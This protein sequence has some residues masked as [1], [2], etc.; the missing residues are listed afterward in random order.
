MRILDPDRTEVVNNADWLGPMHLAEMLGYTRQITVAQL[1]ERDDFARRFA[2]N[3]A[4][5]PVGVLLPAAAGHRLG[6]DPGRHRARRHR[7]DVQ[8]PGR[9]RAAARRADR[10]PRPCSTVPLLVGTDGVEKMG[11]SLGNYIAIDEPA[12]EQFG[13][14][15]SIPDSRGRPVRASC[16]PRCTPREVAEIEAEVEAGRRARRTRPNGGWPARSSRST[17]A[18]T[19]RRRPRQRFDAMFKRGE[20]PADAARHRAAGRGSGP[21]AR[22]CWSRPGSPRAPARPAGTSMPGRS[23]STASRSRPSVRPARDGSS[24]DAVLTVGKRRAVRL[25]VSDWPTKRPGVSERQNRVCLATRG[26]PDLTRVAR[27]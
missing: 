6:R 3:A 15:M 26:A 4:D 27:R 10:R 16:A 19:R 12:A 22:R 9:T 20:V 1:L 5:Q 21:S 8:Q 11:K 23:S 14:L 18:R 25:V 13:K 2:A 24:G 7:P 17:T